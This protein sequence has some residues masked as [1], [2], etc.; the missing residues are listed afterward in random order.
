MEH[1]IFHI[2]TPKLLS[3]ESGAAGGFAKGDD[4][5]NAEES[6]LAPSERVSVL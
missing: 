6:L 1:A 2:N 4:D 3:L 5:F